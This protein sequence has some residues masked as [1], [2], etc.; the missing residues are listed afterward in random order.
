VRVAN[1]SLPGGVSPEAF[2]S[3]TGGV[4]CLSLGILLV[5]VLA[6]VPAAGQATWGRLVIPGGAE[7]AR[8]AIGLGGSDRPAVNFIVDLARA[9]NAQ[10]VADDSDPVG[11]LI[12]Y[13][14]DTG[15]GAAPAA[16]GPVVRESRIPPDTAVPLPL[17][18]LWRRVVFEGN[19]FGLA[20]LASDPRALL[21]YLGL[22]SLDRETL[23]WLAG[24]P[25][26]FEEIYEKRSG[27]FAAFGRSLHV[28]GGRVAVPGGPDEARVWEEIVGARPTDAPAFV[29]R[30]LG[31]NHGR[32]A[33]LYDTAAHLDPPALGFL[34][35]RH[36]S[37]PSRWSERRRL[38]GRVRD[39]FE[40]FGPTWRADERPFFRP[41]VDPALVLSTV[42]VRDDG[43]VGP[44]WWAGVLE[45]ATTSCGWSR[46]R[47]PWR[48]RPPVADAGW[49]LGWVFDRDGVPEERLAVLRLLQRRFPDR[50]EAEIGDIEVTLC[51]RQHM[52]AL[53]LALDRM[54]IASPAIYAD[55][56]LAS[57]RLTHAGDAGLATLRAWQAA[58][59][60]V[61]QSDRQRHI[62]V[63]TTERLLGALSD[64]A[65][66]RPVEPHGAV[67]A[68]MFAELLPTLA[69]D[70][71]TDEPV[72][73]AAFA[74]FV[75]VGL[76]AG[77]EFEWEGL[78]YR[79]DLP[80]A[81]ARSA[82]RVR[83][84]A[85][86]PRLD[87]LQRLFRA[88]ERLGGGGV[89]PDPGA[90]GATLGAL[91][92]ASMAMVDTVGQPIDSALR[93]A[94][95][96][97]IRSV[98]RVER[99]G[100]TPTAEQRKAVL[101]VIDAM[102]GELVPALAYALA[103]SP[104]S[105]PPEIYAESY[106]YHDLGA[107]LP[108]GRFGAMAWAVP[109]VTRRPEGGSRVGGA[110]LGLDLA[111]A[112][113][114]LRRV[115]SDGLVDSPIIT[116]ADFDAS[117]ARLVLSA[118]RTDWPSAGRDVASAIA[119]GRQLVTEWRT[120]PPPD[121][122]VEE[123]LRR[124]AVSEWR[125]SLVR[126]LLSEG[127]R[128]ALSGFF[129]MSDFYRL[130]TTDPLPEAWGQ[131]GWLVESCWCLRAPG[132][133]APED[134]LGRTASL[135]ASVSPDLPLRL[136]ELLA[137]LRLPHALLEPMLPMAL[138]DA[139]DNARQISTADWEAF[140][141]PRHLPGSRVEDY[142]LALLADGKLA[143]P[144]DPRRGSR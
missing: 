139:I 64:A 94:I 136:T 19:D 116:E 22:V 21:L 5:C 42:A 78:P 103:M 1:T 9:A 117:T 134:W 130:G 46:E 62:P 49:L 81:A 90:I 110:M 126:W 6:V 30:V 55:L 83:D 86:G 143:A 23:D 39:R 92:E 88:S 28:R 33:F 138:Q 96:S 8:Q 106:R 24:Q 131:S 36:L 118:H 97:A 140:A 2:T 17:P 52:P 79:L 71:P 114:R 87:H 121:A 135:A 41:V 15:I 47:R 45:R 125:V 77:V 56:T 142:M 34:L 128:D 72:E 82:I 123:T 109:R 10:I 70:G 37:D 73:A 91:R 101:A 67:A 107:D 58:L 124:A 32:L 53:V 113:D 16:S 43:T 25:D 104:V 14:R 74:G 76:D 69:F 18:D 7:A 141:W 29:T 40:E 4:R 61:E 27:P 66:D 93:R 75:G 38:V 13:L 50:P 144:R 119:R 105:G 102:A 31:R 100:S 89:P 111:R 65:P 51:A 63:A 127:D 44:S 112:S 35:G 12:A 20:D 60:L 137:Q 80:A 129:T 115:T 98:E 48:R 85:M 120:D 108:S 68:W 122:V 95:D 59:A 11:Q 57:R 3:A 54:G 132:R 133:R 26:L 99:Q 84:V